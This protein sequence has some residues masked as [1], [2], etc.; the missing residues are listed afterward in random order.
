M[1]LK[2]A[3]DQSCIRRVLLVAV[4]LTNIAIRLVGHDHGPCM[5]EAI[6]D[7][8]TQLNRRSRAPIP[9]WSRTS[10]QIEGRV[11]PFWRRLR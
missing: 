11:L 5:S 8:E 1:Y 9:G 3:K 6:G 4:N 7:A 10:R 2:E